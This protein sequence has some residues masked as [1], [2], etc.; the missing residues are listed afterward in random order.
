[1]SYTG[2]PFIS[3]VTMDHV[4]YLTMERPKALNAL[5]DDLK[6]DLAKALES[7]DKDDTLRV[8]VLS[9]SD[10]GAFSTGGDLKQVAKFGVGRAMTD[11]IELPDIFKAL[12][13][14]GKPIVAA[15]DGYCVGGGL[16]IAL[17]CDLRIAT[18]G[19]TFGL[20][21]PRW[22]MIS[23]YGLD[24]LCRLIPLG[25][26]LRIQLTGARISASRAHQIGLIQEITG[27]RA[28]LF[29]IAGSLARDVVRCSPQAVH[30]IKR[31]VRT[32]RNLPIE[33][34]TQLSQSVRADIHGSA[35]AKE[36]A[37]AFAEKRQPAWAAVPE[38]DSRKDP[39]PL[40]INHAWNE[41]LYNEQA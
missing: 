15:I 31:L 26:A 23:E 39:D 10:C 21:E 6:I 7:F 29:E 12:L 24:N 33:Y 8:L 16:E 17:C 20:P 32:G 19:S 11:G 5:N 34:A 28:E 35:D 41:A 1:M 38:E 25:E 13:Q 9:G 27:S 30:A 22:G 14:V 3:Y 40:P 4:C 2:G 37:R 18:T 36:G